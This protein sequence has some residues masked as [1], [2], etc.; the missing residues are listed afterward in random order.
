MTLG[1][2]AD[3]VRHAAKEFSFFSL[4]SISPFFTAVIYQ[5]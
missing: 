4:H 2:V 5:V 1:N 3:L